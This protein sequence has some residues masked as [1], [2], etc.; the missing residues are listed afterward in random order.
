MTVQPTSALIAWLERRRPLAPFQRRFLRGAFRPGVY[1]AIL[2]GPR[3]LG[4]S[5]LSADV[6]AAYVAP[7]GPLHRPGAESVLLAG[8][9]DQASAAP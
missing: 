4:K 2:S 5:S 7:D 1:T 8:S 6:L 9:L 3:G